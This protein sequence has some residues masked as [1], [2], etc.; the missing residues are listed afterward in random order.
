MAEASAI[1]NAGDP[2]KD[3]DIPVP[4]QY[5]VVH[6]QMTSCQMSQEIFIRLCVNSPKAELFELNQMMYQSIHCAQV[7]FKEG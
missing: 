2:M 7:W 5:R 1:R 4:K 3:E 6:D